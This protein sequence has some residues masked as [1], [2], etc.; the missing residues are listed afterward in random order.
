MQNL[1]KYLGMRWTH[2]GLKM[3]GWEKSSY[4]SIQILED[5]YQMNVNLCMVPIHGE[6]KRKT[7]GV[8]GGY[9]FT[10]GFS[11]ILDPR[12]MLALVQHTIYLL[13]YLK[14]KYI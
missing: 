9:H 4:I 1:L 5:S 3:E 13:D 12:V 2:Q 6:G 8:V 10:S 14:I 11:P 7:V